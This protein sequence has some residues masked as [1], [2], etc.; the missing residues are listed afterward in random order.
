MKTKILF[1]TIMI[2]ISFV[3]CTNTTNVSNKQDKINNIQKPE[4]L[5]SAKTLAPKNIIIKNGPTISERFL[6]PEGYKRIITSKGSFSEFLQN[7]PLKPDGTKVQFY[8]NEYK[9]GLFH[10]AVLE[11]TTGN[12]DLQQCAD[13][14]IRLK[15]E[16]LYQNKQYPAIHFNFVN[17][18]R[19]DYDRW[20][21]GYRIRINNNSTTW[22][23]STTST[24]SYESFLRYLEVVF[25]Y[26]STLSLEKELKDV[27]IKDMDIGDI[28]ITGGSPGHCVIVVDMA[29]NPDTNKKVFMV[30]QGFMPAQ[31]M[32]ILKNLDNEPMSPWYPLDFEGDL[33][34]P[35][36]T[37]A[38]NTLKRF[39]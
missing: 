16:Y 33:K 39:P 26:A 24:T 2:I 28:F 9:S 37:F 4:E 29:V 35:Q 1:I 18:F 23:K 38:Q 12:K 22:F 19:A 7:F 3:S 25:S 27:N 31:D 32:H 8:N 10:D 14:I 11:L 36:W 34:L 13:S 15:A 21:M 6:P 20:R 17:G 5:E 30:A